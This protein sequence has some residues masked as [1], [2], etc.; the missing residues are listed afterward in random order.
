MTAT[1]TQTSIALNGQPGVPGF[2]QTLD[3]T[4]SLVGTAKGS[5][6]STVP[7]GNGTS[8][9]TWEFT[10]TIDGLGT[11]TMTYDRVGVG[12]EDGRVTWMDIVTG[13]T[14]DFEGIAGTGQHDPD[15]AEGAYLFVLTAPVN[16]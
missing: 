10:G 8:Y 3:M 13:G 5:G 14:G 2:S 4:G 1:G 7:V 6:Q 9:S 12:L 11:G 15:G 16:Q